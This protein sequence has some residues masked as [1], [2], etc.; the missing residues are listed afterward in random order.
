MIVLASQ[1]PRRKK[2]LRQLNLSFS[3]EPSSCDELY[4]KNEDPGNIVQNLALRKA[5]DV[6]QS[7]SSAL[8]IGADTLVVFKG[9]ILG[10]PGSEEEAKT[11]L[12]K[13]SG[14]CHSVLT[15]VALVK[16]GSEG[17]ILQEK[18]F[19]EETKVYFGNLSREEIDIYVSEGSPMDKAG[20]YGIQDDWGAIFVK[21]IEGDYY[22]VVGLPLYALYRHL[23][24]F[25]PEVL[26]QYSDVTKHEQ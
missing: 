14:N 19:V 6:S 7:K 9:K 4:N 3:V 13:L 23:K 25:A 8:V 22:N 16:T 15:G 17:N 2:L 18:T 11:M 5:K 24:Q 10:K 12:S 21:R 1:S 20:S 26:L